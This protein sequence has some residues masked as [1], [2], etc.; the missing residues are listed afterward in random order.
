MLDLSGTIDL[1]V[2]FDKDL[3]TVTSQTTVQSIG[4]CF[5]RLPIPGTI[6]CNQDV[7]EILCHK[8]L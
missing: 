7:N 6:T 4:D 2:S 1:V 8:L 5:G 3:M